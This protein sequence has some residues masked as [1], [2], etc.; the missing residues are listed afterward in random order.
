MP[1]NSIKFEFVSGSIHRSCCS[2]L[3]RKNWARNEQKTT[4]DTNLFERSRNEKGQ[5]V[6]AL[7][8]EEVMQSYFLE[9]VRRR[10]L[11]LLIHEF[12]VHVDRHVDSAM[13]KQ[14]L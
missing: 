7:C 1:K 13:P 9:V 5:P 3:T 14:G 12:S 2:L 6:A 8:F 10:L 4:I 11:D